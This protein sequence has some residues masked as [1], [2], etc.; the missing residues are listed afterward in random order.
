MHP[1]QSEK[2]FLSIYQATLEN[3][4]IELLL[5]GYQLQNIVARVQPFWMIRADSDSNT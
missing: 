2:E 4:W 3:R 1:S 5:V